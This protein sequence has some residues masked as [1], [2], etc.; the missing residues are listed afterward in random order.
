[1]LYRYKKD[2]QYGHIF[3]YIEEMAKVA[4]HLRVSE[5]PVVLALGELTRLMTDIRQHGKDLG[6]LYPAEGPCRQLLG[7]RKFADKLHYTQVPIIPLPFPS[8]TNLL[9]GTANVSPEDR[10]VI[11]ANMLRA[12]STMKENMRTVSNKFGSYMDTV[13]GGVN[14]LD[15]FLGFHMDLFAHW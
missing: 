6:F 1:M 12:E 9:E 7:P 13:V 14:R 15:S 11:M 8:I 2:K 4:K 10:D 5:R 3:Q